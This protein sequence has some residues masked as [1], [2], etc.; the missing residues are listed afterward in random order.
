[1]I[2]G[3]RFTG[4]AVLNHYY[5]F[6][7]PQIDYLDEG[8][9]IRFGESY[10]THH[11]YAHHV[12]IEELWGGNADLRAFDEPTPTQTPKKRSRWQRFRDWWFYR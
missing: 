12:F 3:K 8:H 5:G 1:V 7:I 11:N 4:I 2:L 6:Y 9:P 10:T